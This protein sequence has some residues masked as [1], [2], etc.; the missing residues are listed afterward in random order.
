METFVQVG[1]WRSAALLLNLITFFLAFSAF[2]VGCLIATRIRRLLGSGL[3]SGIVTCFLIASGALALRSLLIILHHLALVPELL[4]LVVSD[5]GLLVTGGALFAA[6]LV[7][8][9][10]LRTKEVL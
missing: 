9:R 7:F 6:Y 3:L 4:A 10:F 1:G 5:V 8:E 2:A